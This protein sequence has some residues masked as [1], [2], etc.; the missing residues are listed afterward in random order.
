MLGV[1]L[2][3]IVLVIS[4]G[5]VVMMMVTEWSQPASGSQS[6]PLAGALGGSGKK[7]KKAAAPKKKAPA[8]KKK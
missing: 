7:G 2:G 4:V 5:F 3:V 1:I 8:K 6:L